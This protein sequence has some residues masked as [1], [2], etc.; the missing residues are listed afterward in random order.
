MGGIGVEFDHER[1]R[2][3]IGV[4]LD[5]VDDVVHRRLGQPGAADEGAE[6]ALELGSGHSFV[7]SVGAEDAAQA[8]AAGV[9][10]VA[11]EDP[12]EQPQ[13]EEPELFGS[14]NHPLHPAVVRGCR[15][16]EHGPGPG[17]D[18]DAVPC[19]PVGGRQLRDVEPEFASMAAGGGNRDRDPRGRAA[20]QAPEPGGGGVTRQRW[21]CGEHRR[22]AVP[23]PGQRLVPDRVHTAV[24]P[25]QPPHPVRLRGRVSPV[26]DPRQLTGRDHPM[27]PTR[28]LEK[29]LVPSLL[30]T[31]VTHRVT[32]VMRSWSSPPCVV[33]YGC[34][35]ARGAR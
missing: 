14:S 15:H 33:R 6:A 26:A 22:H 12:V 23:V 1:L 19:R 3:P 17:G 9:V 20:G 16:V 32:K 13:V 34:G 11:L 31:F 24:D 27:L 18:R 2:F 25:S 21:A 8:A 35:A 7:G 5:A 29:R 28:Q 30:M 10:A 4:D